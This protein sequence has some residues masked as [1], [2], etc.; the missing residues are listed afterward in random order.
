MAL[1]SFS[2]VVLE[3]SA[4]S[5]NLVHEVGKANK[6]LSLLEKT[7]N[8]VS[9]T[10]Q[11]V[12]VG[13][14]IYG[15]IQGFGNAIK[16]IADFDKSM[17]QVRVITGATG[18]DFERLET[19]ALKLGS[20]T[21]YT[22]K[23]VSELQ[24]EFG[25]LGFTT[26]EILQSTSA[27][28]DLATATGEG[29]ARSAEI[30]GSTLRAFNLDASEMGRVTDVMAASLNE[31]ALTLDSFADGIKYVAPVAAAT[32]VTLEETAAMMSVLADAGIKGTQAGTSLRRIFTLLTDTGKPLQERLD[33]LA[34]AGITLAQAN[35]EVGLYAQTALLVLTKYK[36]RIDELTILFNE[37]TGSTKEMALAMQDNLGTALVKVGTAWDALILSFSK[38]K[39]VLKG[40]ADTTSSIFRVLASDKISFAEKFL[41]VN[42][43]NAGTFTLL[44][45]KMKILDQQAQKTEDSISNFISDSALALAKDYGDDIDGVKNA[46]N[47][48]AQGQ[49]YFNEILAEYATVRKEQLQSELD[50]IAKNLQAS[51]DQ[52]KAYK[53]QIA[54]ANELGNAQNKRILEAAAVRDFNAGAGARSAAIRSG[55]QAG[56][57]NVPPPEPESLT[58]WDIAIKQQE[59]YAVA[60]RKAREEAM[61]QRDADK[62][63]LEDRR[64][65]FA[66]FADQVGNSITQVIQHEL[67]LGQ[68]F[69]R[70]TA[71][72][73]DGIQ[74]RIIANIAL[75]TS[76]AFAANPLLGIAVV[77]AGFAVA[78]GLLGMISKSGGGGSYGGGSNLS[79]SR[80]SFETATNGSQ[81]SAPTITGLIRGQDLYVILENYKRNNQYTMSGG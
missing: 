19:S 65:A 39:G 30:A 11:G 10:F 37:A 17:T 35:D 4:T 33:D 48:T 3:I 15:I 63:A 1:G 81:N 9:S 70:V 66:Q 20:T 69:A 67:S 18:R 13:G 5:A 76:K 73:L 27:V 45:E 61:Q 62:Q 14:G 58:L 50:L 7:A 64:F 57:F 60:I 6:S 26:K 49:K 47:G 34:K 68:A 71:S 53:E 2:K 29:L 22:A 78:K 28:V 56:R 77:T 51:E 42:S 74:Q 79:P 21:Q 54:L 24:L 36:P 52:I 59:E 23:Q 72:I 41:A 43:L 55:E 40:V 44:A 16:T 8:R 80:S 38:S 46:I 31:S 25:R 12:L 32:N 75:G